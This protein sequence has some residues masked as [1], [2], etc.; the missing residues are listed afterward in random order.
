MA[1]AGSFAD[2]VK[3]QADIVRVVG[4]YV[5]LRKNGQNFTGLCPFHSEKTPSFAVHPVKQIYHCFGCGVGGDV[6]KFIMEI[7][8]CDF[9]EAVRAVA[10]KCG[11]AIP[12]SR[13]SSPEERREQQQR[14]A[15]VEVHREAAAFFARQLEGTPEGKAAR[16]Y[17][18]DRGLDVEAIARFGLGYAPSGGDALLR[19]LKA[20]YPEKL[21]E[22]AGLASRDPSGRPHDRFRRR[23]IFPIANESGKVV[24]FGGRALGDD[25]PKYLNSPETPIYIKSGVLYHLDRA[26]ETI[27]QA[28]AAILVE[29]YMDTIAVAQSGI[30]NVVASCGTSLTETQVKLLSRFTRRIIV[31][32]D[33][34]AA[35]QAAT[36]R[37]LSILLEHNCDVRVLA[38]P[39]GK[40][41]DTFIRSEGA[42]AYRKLL[43]SAPAYLDY[44]IGRAR[45]HGVAGAEQKL[46]A[47]NFLMPFVQ[48][49][50]NALLRSEW[51]SRI[52]HELRVDEP[53]LREALRRAAAERRSEVKTQPALAGRTVRPAERRL[54]QMLM[55][56]NDFRERLGEEIRAHQLHLGLETERIL[57]ALLEAGGGALPEATNVAPKLEEYDRRLLFEIAFES[58]AESSWEE[59]ESCLEVLRR[60][61]S[62]EELASVQRQIEACAESGAGGDAE[63]LR[64]LQARKLELRRR[65]ASMAP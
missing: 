9:P 38:L 31:N 19:H 21:V 50:P 24:A 3:Q 13:E 41:P 32:Y 5:R 27:R 62:E 26:K 18:A 39:G 14:T 44:L 20:K 46:R 54:V 16:G 22:L 49:I 30:S 63:E 60:R 15:L 48:R 47:M 56:E 61:K 1:E 28:D 42:A 57:R 52:A 37:S 17:L 35:G 40:D 2:R 51:A 25:L 65:L 29:G 43:E 6:F 23:I 33:P 59:A 58:G 10:D 64:A 8:K 45:Q 36:E 12:R 34:D 11:I 4:E 55:E 7:E 53:V